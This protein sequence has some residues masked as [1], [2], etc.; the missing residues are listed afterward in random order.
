MNVSRYAHLHD[1]LSLSICISTGAHAHIDCHVYSHL[2]NR[3]IVFDGDNPTA[4]VRVSLKRILLTSDAARGRADYEFLDKY[5]NIPPHLF[6]YLC[7]T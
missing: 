1:I 7:M 3:P 2:S 5:G 4:D 6:I